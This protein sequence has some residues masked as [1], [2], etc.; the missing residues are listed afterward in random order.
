[1]TFKSNLHPYTIKNMGKIDE[2]VQAIKKYMEYLEAELDHCKHMI[3]VR[4][5]SRFYILNTVNFMLRV[6]NM[7]IP[8]NMSE[9]IK[10]YGGKK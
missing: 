8:L 9:I 5:R 6:N 4:N 10:K 3:D 1:M 2:Q 7:N